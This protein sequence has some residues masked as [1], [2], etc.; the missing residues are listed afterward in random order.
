MRLPTR[1]VVIGLAVLGATL[2]LVAVVTYQI[3]RVTGRQSVDRALRDELD[4]VSSAFPALIDEQGEVTAED[5]QRAAHEYLAVHP[6]TSRH[7]TVLVIGNDTYTTRSGPDALLD[8]DEDGELPMGRPG[9]LTTEGTDEGPVRVLNTPLLGDGATIGRAIIAASLQ[10]VQDDAADALVGIAGGGLIG[11]VFGGV[12]LTLS[13]RRA[14][15]PVVELASAARG[16]GGGDLTTRVPEPA[17]R[18]E[19]GELATEFNRMLD[20]IHADAEH[21]RR[22]LSA[23]SHELRTPLA[24]A[25]GHLEIFETL[26]V[27][28]HDGGVGHGNAPAQLAAIIRGEL[29]RLTRVTDDLE[30]I[31]QGDAA[32]NIELGP[33]FIPDVFDELRQRLAGL[34]IIGV[35]LR[36]APPV[37]VEADQHRIAQALLNLVSNAVT[38]TTAGTNVVVGAA[39]AGPNLNVEVADDGPGIDPSIR[40]NIFEPFVTTRADGSTVG[41]GLGLAIVK[42]LIEAQRGTIEL[43]TGPSGT[44]ATIRLPLAPVDDYRHPG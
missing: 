33:V 20:R 16:T 1:L 21:R 2:L 23:V 26:D 18:D 35:E 31:L 29:D 13:T 28:A 10:D 3:V 43:V 6:G 11:L 32:T 44:R 41:R 7:L 42:N 25:R 15:R 40:D 14:V 17:R 39:V 36:E 19:V 37:V 12:A 24:V 5:L 9:H 8:L 4:T 27:A 38:H 30:A 34:G 22:L